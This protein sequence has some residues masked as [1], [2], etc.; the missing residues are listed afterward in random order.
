MSC[1]EEWTQ[2]R[3]VI[4]LSRTRPL[5]RAVPGHFAYLYAEMVSEGCDEWGMVHPVERDG[6]GGPDR[7]FCLQVLAGALRPEEDGSEED[8]HLLLG[9]RRERRG[10][11]QQQGG[12]SLDAASV[13]AF[14]K[15]WQFHDFTQ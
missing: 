13:E 2:T 4:E 8:D 14:K 10:G 11:I 5:A 7:K 9:L 15:D 1:E 3:K 12:S 6:S